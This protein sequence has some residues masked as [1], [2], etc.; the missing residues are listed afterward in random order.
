MNLKDAMYNWLQ[1][2]IVVEARP[3]DEAALETLD[4]FD[5]ILKDDHKVS[6]IELEMKE[7]YYHIHYNI[8]HE[9]DRLTLRFDQELAEKLLDEINSNPKYNEQ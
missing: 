7:G 8:D 1:M 3:H 6:E 5:E 9:T 2:K 4:F